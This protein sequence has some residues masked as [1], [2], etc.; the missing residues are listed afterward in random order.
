MTTQA[1]TFG[2]QNHAAFRNPL[3]QSYRY[4]N[5]IV[6]TA[7]QVA[8]LAVL[9]AWNGIDAEMCAA[10]PVEP[11]HTSPLSLLT[12]EVDTL[13]L[14]KTQIDLFSNPS[15]AISPSAKENLLDAWVAGQ[16]SWGEVIQ[17]HQ[18]KATY[19]QRLVKRA[20]SVLSFV[21]GYARVR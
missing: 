6:L 2:P 12:D 11:S 16:A 20:Y 5:P 17:A 3:R 4:H 21:G 9:Q 18:P 10:A 13:A 7:D 8:D 14:V 15:P 19:T 1:Q